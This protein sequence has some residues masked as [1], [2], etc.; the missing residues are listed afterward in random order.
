[1][2]DCKINDFSR[3]FKGN[4]GLPLKSL[5][6]EFTRKCNFSCRHCY[7]TN[8]HS[9]PQ[10]LSFSEWVD[11]FEQ[12]AKE[13]GLFI[14]ITGGE[15]LLYKDFARLWQY[16]KKRGF[17]LTLFSNASL[18][19]KDFV[20][21]FCRWTPLQV[22]VTLYGASNETYERAT[23]CPNMFSRVMESLES[24]RKKGIPLEVK[25]VFSKFNADDFEDVRKI[26][27]EY[28]DLFRWDMALMGA[29]ATSE[30]DPKAIRLS[31]AEY[32]E[33]EAKEPVRFLHMKKVF[34]Q[35]VP[36]GL[37][38]NRKGAFACNVRAGGSFYIDSSGKMHPCIPFECYGYDLMKGT[39]REGWHEEM[40]K[41]IETFPCHPGA[42][43]S[44]A[45]V[46]LCGPC[47]AF[48]LLEGCS[49]SGPVPYKCELVKARAEKYSA[50]RV[51]RFINSQDKY[52]EENHGSRVKKEDVDN[53]NS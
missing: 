24:L 44:C 6:V 39:L 49:V 34:Q 52:K 30:N 23:G 29:F 38:P 50:E 17:I 41:F 8:Q 14:T 27:L 19:D 2:I 26:A 33:M 48:A 47:A 18:I 35:W 46:E 40:P 21:F 25:G 28:C 13:D 22:S 43:Q 53:A 16:L 4:T 3:K 32:V 36:P 51:I 7:C 12:Y 42:C 9:I 1:M 45:L 11:I 31:P 37:T 15:P 5:S 10:E 20:D